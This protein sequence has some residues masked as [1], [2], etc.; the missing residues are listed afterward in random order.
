MP[1]LHVRVIDPS[2]LH[3][4]PAARFV[5]AASRFTSAISIGQGQRFVDAKSLVALLSL[6]V[7]PGSELVLR[8]EGGDASGALL[9]LATE[10]APYVEPVAG[11]TDG[12]DAA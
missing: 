5:Q 3:A 4:R 8:A 12:R 10:L 2:G 6:G 11:Q 7:R 1:E 9:T